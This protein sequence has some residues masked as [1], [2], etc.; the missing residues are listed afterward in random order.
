[1]ANNPFHDPKANPLPDANDIERETSAGEPT[2]IESSQSSAD[3]HQL[4]KIL[5]GLLG[6]GLALGVLT[7]TGIV[8]VL[9]RAG[10]SEPPAVERNLSE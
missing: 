10:L 6:I 4:R 2:H 7:A 9:N 3:R 5:I 8:W 1:M